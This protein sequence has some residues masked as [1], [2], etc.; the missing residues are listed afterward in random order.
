MPGWYRSTMKTLFILMLS[1]LTGVIAGQPSGSILQVG[2]IAPDFHGVNQT[3]DLVDL[4]K[5]LKDGPVVL[6]FFRGS[7]CYYCNKHIS[8][9]QDSLE[10]VL[11]KGASVIAVSPQIPEFNQKTISKTG[12]EFS[13][14]HDTGYQIMDA[15][16]VSFTM[17]EKTIKQYRR[18]G[19]HIGRANA[20]EDY[21]LPVPATFIIGEDGMIRYIQYD[22]NYK[23]RSTVAEVLRNL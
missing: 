2:D 21:I 3:N 17:E 19:R 16:Y 10:Y 20:N 14:I 8:K 9:F 23:N 4:R 12:A 22:P 18:F 13:I 1:I 11:D 15:Y 7:W 6:I 5:S